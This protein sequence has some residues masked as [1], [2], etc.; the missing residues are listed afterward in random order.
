M[1]ETI[2]HFRDSL[3]PLEMETRETGPF[4]TTVV[5]SGLSQPESEEVLCPKTGDRT[6]AVPH[7]FCELSR[8]FRA[9][10]MM[11]SGGREGDSPERFFGAGLSPGVRVT[12]FHYHTDFYFAT[13]RLPSVYV[14]PGSRELSS[15]EWGYAINMECVAAFVPAASLSTVDVLNALCVKETELGVLHESMDATEFHHTALAMALQVSQAVILCQDDGATLEFH[16]G[17]LSDILPCLELLE[18]CLAK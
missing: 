17:Q 14:L 10:I 8:Q 9:L 15:G 7:L 4:A 18:R 13:D 2:E 16:G 3:R 1:E 6:S 5:V 11:G 12:Y